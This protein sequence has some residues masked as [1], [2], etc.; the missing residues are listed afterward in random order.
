MALGGDSPAVKI[1][2]YAALGYDIVSA[3]NSS[4]QTAELNAQA[5][6]ETL[7]KWVKLAELQIAGFALF[8]MLLDRSVWPGVGAALAGGIMWIQ[9]KH[10]IEAGLA[11][12]GQPTEDYTTGGRNAV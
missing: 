12:P 7:M 2:V 5:R 1:G 11:N 10:A 9:Y 3:V 4:P 6:A 8:G